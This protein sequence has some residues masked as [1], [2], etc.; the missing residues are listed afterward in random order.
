VSSD[1]AS[2]QNIRLAGQGC[3]RLVAHPVLDQVYLERDWVGW[4]V[5]KYYAWRTDDPFEKSDRLSVVARRIFQTFL[6]DMARVEAHLDNHYAL[7]DKRAAEEC[8]TASNLKGYRRTILHF[9]NRVNPLFQDPRTP[10]PLQITR[11]KRAFEN[12]MGEGR[13][14]LAG[15]PSLI[16]RVESCGAMIELEVT[17]DEE[18][19]VHLL[20]PLATGTLEIGL[21]VDR[22]LR[23]WVST[24]NFMADLNPNLLHQALTHLV[25]DSDVYKLEC[26]L[27]ERGLAVFGRE[28][29][30]TV[31]WRE[32]LGPG[33]TVNVAGEAVTIDGFAGMW[34]GNDDMYQY[35]LKGSNRVLVV[36]QNQAQLG[37]YVHRMRDSALPALQVDRQDAR[38]AI[39]ENPGEPLTASSESLASFLQSM[40]ADQFLIEPLSQGVLRIKDGELIC[41]APVR[42]T[43]YNYGTLEEFVWSLADEYESYASLMLRS[44]L[45]ASKEAVAFREILAEAVAD[46]KKDLAI[47]LAFQLE[48]NKLLPQLEDAV[49]RLYKIKARIIN[50]IAAKRRGSPAQLKAAVTASLQ[51]YI[52][53]RVV[54]TH[55]PPTTAEDLFKQLLGS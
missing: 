42:R 14:D 2:L 46:R 16:D 30:D 39:Y 43:D 49:N 13:A 52:N 24:L 8:W 19:P 37:I 12:V 22:T 5:T 21:G 48:S 47:A 1:I 31:A 15:L 32:Q 41:V 17:S 50:R 40:V 34:C 33:G 28:D 55:L 51:A 26:E 10:G 25:D 36:G 11:F 3:S 4:A 45:S 27:Q 7:T 38:C 29:T 35:A 9:R 53:S 20:R 54:G 44:G 18:M 6:A 23:N